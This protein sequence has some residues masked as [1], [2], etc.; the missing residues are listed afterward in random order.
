LLCFC[1]NVQFEAVVVLLGGRWP[2]RGLVSG[3][4]PPLAL[5][6]TI[7]NSFTGIPDVHCSKVPSEVHPSL[8]HNDSLL[9]T[10]SPPSHTDHGCVVE[11]R[12]RQHTRMVEE[13]AETSSFS[14]LRHV[15]RNRGGGH[16]VIVH[17]GSVRQAAQVLWMQVSVVDGGEY[18]GCR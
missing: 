11:P 2:A 4:W 13:T 7:S 1:V 9:G 15:S 14:S 5:P 6:A 18:C 12:C 8:V 3:R 16:T 17:C 10:E